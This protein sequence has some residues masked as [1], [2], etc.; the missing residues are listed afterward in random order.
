MLPAS[1][2]QFERTNIISASLETMWFESVSA[3]PENILPIQNTGSTFQLV[4]IPSLFC[5]WDILLVWKKE[6]VC[7]PEQQWDFHPE[8]CQMYKQATFPGNE[9]KSENPKNLYMIQHTQA[10][11]REGDECIINTAIARPFLKATAVPTFI[12][13]FFF[14]HR[15]TN[16]I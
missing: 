12:T 13:F 14:K 11:I 10:G 8:K 2:W 15:F 7:L 6:D 5:S 9:Q 16:V 3:W 1:Q 4:G